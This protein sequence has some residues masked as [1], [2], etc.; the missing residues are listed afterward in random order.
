[1]GTRL[2]AAA[3]AGKPP[4][5]FILGDPEHTE[6]DSWDIKL[7]LAY[8]I[9]EELSQGGVP[10]YW[11][12]SDRVRF[13]AESY[14]SK[15]KAAVDRAEEKASKGNT[16]NYGKIFYPKPQTVDGGPLPTLEEWLE[17]SRLKHEMGAGK[18]RSGPIDPF[19]NSNWKPEET[20]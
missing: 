17:E 10:V 12:R 16:K 20:P 2:K 8:Q 14:I 1:M 5:M 7:A 18:I 13:T 11:D 6:W 15:S 9:S 19:D 3:T 4:L